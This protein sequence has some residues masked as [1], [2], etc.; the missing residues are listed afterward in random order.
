MRKIKEKKISYCVIFCLVIYSI[1]AVTFMV[2]TGLGLKNH[3]ELEVIKEVFDDGVWSEGPIE[4]NIGDTLEFRITLTYHNTSGEPNLHY[5]YSIRVNDS[6]PECLDYDAGSADPLT[7][8]LWS[9]DP[10]EY[11]YW[12]FG[13]QPLFN[14][15][16]LNVTYNATVVNESLTGFTTPQEN[17]ASVLWNEFCTGGTNLE[18]FDTLTI[19][20][21]EEPQLKI[22]K[23]VE[24]VKTY[25]AYEGET[26]HFE[27]NVSNTGSIDLTGVIANDT[28]PEFITPF[29][30][31]ISM[32]ID[33]T[34]RTITWDL[35]SIPAHTWVTI[36]LNAT[37]N[38][39]EGPPTSGKNI[40]NVTCDQDLFDE[41]FVT[42]FVGKKFIVDKKVW[43]PEKGEWAEEIPYVKGCQPVRF[44]INL[45]Y[46]GNNPMKCLLLNDSLP[47]CLEFDNESVY[48]EIAGV[49]I[50]PGEN[51]YPDIYTQ[52]D[53]FQICNTQVI[54]PIGNISFSWIEKEFYLVKNESVII[55][56]EASVI[57]YCEDGQCCL[58]QNCIE[59]WLWSCC[60]CDQP[61]Y[62]KDCVDVNCSACPGDFNK[63]VSNI[64]PTNWVKEIQTVQ[65]YFI[66]FKL[67]LIYYGNHNLT[68]VTFKDIL[69]CCLE[70]QSTIQ[71]PTGTN[72]DVSDDKKTIWW[73]LSQNVTDCQTVTIIFTAE[74]TGSGSC[75]ACINHGYVYGW[76]YRQC[77]YYY[78]LV[79]DETDTATIYAKANSSPSAPDVSGPNEGIVG[80]TYSFIAMLTD[81]DGD[82]IDYKFDW[83]DGTSTDWIEGPTGSGEVT[84]THA[85]STAKTYSVKAKAR[86]E[87]GAESAWTLIPWTIVIKTAKVDLSL[88]FFNWHNVTAYV[89]NT[90]EAAISG[91]Q[92]EFNISRDAFL[93]FRDINF[94]GNGNI[95][96]LPVG[97]DATI[98]SDSITGF[99]FGMVDVT[100]TVTKTG[101]I[102]PT[103]ITAQAFIIGPMILVLPDA[104]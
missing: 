12:D 41:D 28:Y 4:T 57:Q 22:T 30:S 72:I 63:T 3:G 65:G 60:T 82:Q 53:T 54:V 94:N 1:S 74:V 47:D 101:I 69:P 6:L 86:D 71:S 37:V 59:A 7:G 14:G 58:Q 103:T 88:K 19:N 95:A 21:G 31:N 38:A 15:E 17:N 75:G 34:N 43:D 102:S 77:P 55:E 25:D 49:I 13:D 24:G 16:S 97:G 45:S 52:G 36:L 40:A 33:A 68:N 50:N 29:E 35:D 78:K 9:D 96:N 83:G 89:E 18:T 26:L 39:I 98:N 81:P 10:N 80:A 2:D 64:D 85:F 11:L 51:S 79:V 8:F 91:L 62:G 42:I 48:I 46:Y 87:H 93:N 76:I 32:T 104:S 66:K 67:E 23:L 99:R 5:A 44:R 100:V 20:V 73:N 61:L 70:Y 27:I 56:F 92:Y 90:G 84:Q